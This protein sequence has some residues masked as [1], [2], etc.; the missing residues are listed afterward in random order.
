MLIFAVSQKTGIMKNTFIL[1]CTVLSMSVSYGQQ[2][3]LTGPKVK[4]EKV[5]NKEAKSI[6]VYHAPERETVTG[7]KAKNTRVWQKQDSVK[8]VVTRKNR[9]DLTGPRYKNRKPWKKQ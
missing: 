9:E 5:W 7:P 6:E 2:S 4:N 3:A 1:I 8:K